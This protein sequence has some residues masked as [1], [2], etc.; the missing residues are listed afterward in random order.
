VRAIPLVGRLLPPGQAPRWGV[1]A[2]Y[3][4]RIRAVPA[5]SCTYWPCFEA[6]LLDTAP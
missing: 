2:S 5:A 1:L 3:R 6:L 4:V